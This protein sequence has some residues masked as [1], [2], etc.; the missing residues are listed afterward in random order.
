VSEFQNV[1]R[2]DED[3]ILKRNDASMTP[4]LSPRTR[5]CMPPVNSAVSVAIQ[6]VTDFSMLATNA[7]GNRAPF[8]ILPMKDVS[9][10]SNSTL[11]T[12]PLGNPPPLAALRQMTDTSEIHVDPEHEV[13]ANRIDKVADRYEKKRPTISIKAMPVD[14]RSETFEGWTRG[15]GYDSPPSLF[16]D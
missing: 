7:K 11:A 3:P 4:I 13:T 5:I 8:V 12:M 2:E 6:G 1:A 16:E 9:E 10:C 14:A 15:S